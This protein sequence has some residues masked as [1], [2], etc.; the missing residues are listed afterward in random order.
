MVDWTS[1]AISDSDT[2]SIQ[3]SGHRSRRNYSRSSTDL[4]ES[5]AEPNSSSDGED[6]SEQSQTVGRRSLRISTK[7]QEQNLASGYMLDSEDDSEDGPRRPGRPRTKQIHQTLA[8]S[9]SKR[10]APRSAI[11]SISDSRAVGARRSERTRDIP[12]RNMREIQEDEISANSENETGPKVVA[13]KEQFHR[14]PEH[15]PF[16]QRHRQVCDTCDWLGDDAEKGPLVFCQGCTNAYHVKC[17]GPR[18]SRD[19]IVT[20]VAENNFV[21][22]CRRCIGLAHQKDHMAPDHG[23]CTGCEESGNASKPFRARLSTRQEQ[24]PRE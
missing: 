19:H 24:I 8:S 17:L 23:V 21:L 2:S 16:R 10:G 9:R 18:G 6:D 12:R 14:F 3:R 4:N 15:H 11:A 7:Q 1:L 20:K 22:Q 5:E 13:T